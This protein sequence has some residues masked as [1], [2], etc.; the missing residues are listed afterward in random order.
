MLQPISPLPLRPVTPPD[1][2]LTDPVRRRAGGAGAI[3]L[4][5]RLC[6]RWGL[7]IDEQ[8]ALL[9]DVSRPTYHR[10]RKAAEAGGTVEL[11]RDQMERVSLC[12][13]IEKGLKTIFARDEAGLRWLK[14]ANTDLPFGGHA[15]I[16]VMM[17][18][19]L[20]ALHRTRA[21]LDA[22]RGGR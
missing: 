7:S 12:L 18:G 10:W 4:F 3:K 19:G 11:T 1:T 17:Q 9:G 13:G 2:I 22:W 8:R 21:Y 6:E 14:A 20:F 15:P 5:A 16:E